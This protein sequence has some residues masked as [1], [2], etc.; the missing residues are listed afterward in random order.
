[1]V[2]WCFSSNTESIKYF[3][4]GWCI[5]QGKSVDFYHSIFETCYP[6]DELAVQGPDCGPPLLHSFI[7]IP[8]MPF[9][10]VFFLTPRSELY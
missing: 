6:S 5:G 3:G 10:D 9:L 1:M 2:L 7:H 4:G 8:L